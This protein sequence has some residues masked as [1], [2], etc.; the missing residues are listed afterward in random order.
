VPDLFLLETSKAPLKD[1]RG[2]PAQRVRGFEMP[3]SL[4]SRFSQNRRLQSFRLRLTEDELARIEKAY[5]E[6][7]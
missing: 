1:A 4:D 3:D 2:V 7:F 6:I 5:S